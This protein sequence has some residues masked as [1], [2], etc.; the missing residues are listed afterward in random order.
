MTLIA[1]SIDPPFF[2]IGDVLMSANEKIPFVPPAAPIDISQ[3]L[4][5][6]NRVWHPYE[7]RRKIYILKQNLVFAFSGN[8]EEIKEFL[9]E[10]KIKCH[11]YDDEIKIESVHQI[12]TQYDFNNLFKGSSFFMMHINN[13]ELLATSI[14]R[15]NWNSVDNETYHQMFA[16]GSGSDGYLYWL[17]EKIET[18]SSHPEDDVN[19]LIQVNCAFIGRWGLAVVVKK[20]GGSPIQR[21]DPCYNQP[22]WMT[23]GAWILWKTAWKIAGRSAPSWTDDYNNHHRHGSLDDKSPSEYAA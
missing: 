9:K 21:K 22:L 16:N 7:L 2:T 15:D 11:D 18:S 14:T 5:E 19:Q 23:H 3:I 12:L 8:G 10:L 17:S 1:H 6:P 4:N 20:R 13:G